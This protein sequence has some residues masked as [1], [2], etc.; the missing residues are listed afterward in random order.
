MDIIIFLLRSTNFYIYLCIGTCFWLDCNLTVFAYYII[1]AQEE[2]FYILA[3]AGGGDS[4]KWEHSNMQPEAGAHR[5]WESEQGIVLVASYTFLIGMNL[6]IANC[7][8]NL[9]EDHCARYNV[10]LYRIVMSVCLNVE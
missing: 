9:K 4:V 1:C 8:R 6:T 2:T 5:L 7:V 10:R 3:A